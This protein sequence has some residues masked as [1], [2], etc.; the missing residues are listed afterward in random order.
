[1]KT[2]SLKEAIRMKTKILEVSLRDRE[3]AAKAIE[4]AAKEIAAGNLVVIPTETSYGIAADATNAEA[5][6]K[7]FELK[8]RD[9]SKPI[10]LIVSDL[11][12]ARQYSEINPIA[13]HLA[14]AFM[15]G[16]LTLVVDKKPNIPDA[17]NKG[18]VAFRISSNT[19]A[20]AISSEAGLPITATSANKSGEPALYSAW[21]VRQAFDGKVPLIILSGDLQQVPASTVIDTRCF[22][23]ALI[24]EGP[25]PY[26]E[27]L[28]ELAKFAPKGTASTATIAQ[29]DIAYQNV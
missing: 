13:E 16:P 25:V 8:E 6:K 9:P 22:P 4:L 10:P 20:R 15:P 21:Q 23:P 1:V 29:T 24:R 26:S 14:Q 2:R 5:V 27:I 18:G 12:L 7:I 17:V 3:K 11:N 28:A 19:F